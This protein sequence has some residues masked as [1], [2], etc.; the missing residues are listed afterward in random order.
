[1]LT[2]EEFCSMGKKRLLTYLRANPDEI[3]EIHERYNLS[4]TLTQDDLWELTDE[5]P[6]FQDDIEN[7]IVDFDFQEYSK[8]YWEEIDDGY[9]PDDYYD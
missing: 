5:C 7:I 1:M 3:A 6:E 9:D 4:N 8:E 2:D